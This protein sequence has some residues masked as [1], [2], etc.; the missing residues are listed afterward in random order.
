MEIKFVEEADTMREVIKRCTDLG[1]LQNTVLDMLA[2]NISI[3]VMV[4]YGM[5]ASTFLLL[6]C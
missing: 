4:F 5:R 3:Y 1:W 6:R 2:I